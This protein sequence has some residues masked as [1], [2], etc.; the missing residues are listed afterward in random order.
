L[1]STGNKITQRQLAYPR[2]RG[3]VAG[4]GS[5][6][7]S[8][9]NIHSDVTATAN[10]TGSGPASTPTT[11]S[12]NPSIRPPGASAPR[13]PMTP[14]RTTSQQ[15]RLRL[16][17]ANQ[18]LYEHTG[19]LAYTEMGARAYVGALGRFLTTD[20]SKA[21]TPHYNYPNDPV[22]GLTSTDVCMEEIHQGRNCGRWRCRCRCV[23]RRNRRGCTGIVI[24][25]AA[26]SFGSNIYA[27]Y[28][29]DMS[30]GEVGINAA[31]DFGSAFIPGGRAVRS[32]GGRHWA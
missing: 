10:S 22:N 5:A 16:V 30:W 15:L 19:T 6:V 20:P 18:K 4:R 9:P 14:H 31:F 11:R 23:H 26:A 28:K 1:L 7:W 8:Y 29:E 21:A 32:I 12:A 24:G 17:G 3:L 25:V 13:W 2:G 27:H